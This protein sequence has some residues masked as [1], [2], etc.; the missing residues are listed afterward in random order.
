MTDKF[1]GFVEPTG[2]FT[3]VPNDALYF[4]AALSGAAFKC[5]MYI[6]RHT[7]GFHDKAKAITLD[8]FANGRKRNDESR[9]DFGTGLSRSTVIDELPAL[10]EQG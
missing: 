9:I 4:M 10:S 2:N 8:E 1:A 6:V 5:L 7:F 3:I